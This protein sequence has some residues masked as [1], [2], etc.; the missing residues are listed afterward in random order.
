MADSGG[1]AKVK[2]TLAKLFEIAYSEDKGVTTA[3]VK[4][5]G[6]FTM[7]IDEDGYV[8]LSGKAGIVKFVG[9]PELEQMGI[10][11]EYGSVMLS[12][13]GNNKLG[14]TASLKFRGIIKIEYSNVIDVEKLLLGCSGLLCQAARGLKNREK[15]I[16]EALGGAF[17]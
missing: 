2:L 16:E 17:R 10:D 15:Q 8:T 4:S 13:I 1:Q 9:K 14:Y 11:L 5:K 12:N 3:L 6:P 7:R